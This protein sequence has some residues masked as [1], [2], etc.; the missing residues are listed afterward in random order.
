MS[1]NFDLDSICIEICEFIIYPYQEL[2]VAH[3]IIAVCYPFT[4]HF[5]NR[6]TDIR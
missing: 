4:I 6:S 2:F 3:L 1:N 5:F